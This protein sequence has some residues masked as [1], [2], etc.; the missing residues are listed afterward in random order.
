MDHAAKVAAV[1]LR[2]EPGLVMELDLAPGHLPSWLI[3][4]MAHAVGKSINKTT[5]KYKIKIKLQ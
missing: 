1:E 3:V 5:N 2:L 4:I